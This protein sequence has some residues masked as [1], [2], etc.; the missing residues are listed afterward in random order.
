MFIDLLYL[1][2]PVYRLKV[3]ESDTYSNVAFNAFSRADEL[4]EMLQSARGNE[5]VFDYM[6]TTR[7][8]KKAYQDF[9]D[10]MVKDRK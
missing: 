5:E 4:T 7:R 8:V 3:F 9:I 2:Y 6:C 1:G 10:E